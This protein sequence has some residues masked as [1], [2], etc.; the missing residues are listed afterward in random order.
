MQRRLLRFAAVILLVSACA[1]TAPAG[2]DSGKEPAGTIRVSPLPGDRWKLTFESQS[3]PPRPMRLS[4]EEARAV[5]AGFREAL[6]Q[7]LLACAGACV[8]PDWEQRLREEYL[9]RYGPSVRSLPKSLEH[10]PP[11][12]SRP[13]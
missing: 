3:H 1:T 8:A 10:S 6:G 7:E 5:L 11:S 2:K 12:P 13:P 4:V 9:A